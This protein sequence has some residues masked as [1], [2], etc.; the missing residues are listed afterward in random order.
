MVLTS[1]DRPDRGT[2]NRSKVPSACPAS[3]RGFISWDPRSAQGVNP[4]MNHSRILKIPGV[5]QFKKNTKVDITLR[6][7]EMLRRP[8]VCKVRR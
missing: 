1:C 7:K 2:Q 8:V 3:Y 5:L 4:G 6:K